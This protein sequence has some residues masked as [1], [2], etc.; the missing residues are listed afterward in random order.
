[1]DTDTEVKVANRKSYSYQGTRTGIG[2]IQ[3]VNEEQNSYF[4][5][6]F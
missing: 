3:I 2:N 4:L 1:M 6:L 5:F